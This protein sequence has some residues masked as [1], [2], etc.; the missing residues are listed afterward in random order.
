MFAWGKHVETPWTESYKNSY[1]S[2]SCSP[3][4]PFPEFSLKLK[5]ITMHV[6]KG[7]GIQK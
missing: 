7:L 4:F 3:L 1:K 2:L 5:Q 6:Y